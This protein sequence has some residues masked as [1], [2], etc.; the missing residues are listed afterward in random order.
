MNLEFAF[1]QHGVKRIC[2]DIMKFGS[3]VLLHG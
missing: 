3:F 1:L 2:V